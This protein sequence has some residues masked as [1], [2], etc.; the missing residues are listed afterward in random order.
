FAVLARVLASLG[1]VRLHGALM[2]E[3]RLGGVLLLGDRGAGTASTAAR[4]VHEGGP[5][6]TDDTVLVGPDGR[7]HGLHR[8]L[9]VD[10]DLT[11]RLPGLPGL[12]GSGEEPPRRRRP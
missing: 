2:A 6:A 8:E 7:F 12:A 11:P 4:W 5:V 9:H 3:A 10:P 1:V